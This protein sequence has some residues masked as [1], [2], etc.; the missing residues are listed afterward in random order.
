MLGASNLPLP[1][2]TVESKSPFDFGDI[3]ILISQSNKIQ[4]LIER[5]DVSAQLLSNKSP[6][7]VLDYDGNTSRVMTAML[8]ARGVEAYSFYDGMPG[9]MKHLSLKN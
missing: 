3:E 5:P 8:R 2:L 1:D 4:A 9:L 6:L 7:V